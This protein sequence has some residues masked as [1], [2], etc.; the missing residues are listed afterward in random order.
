MVH[1]HYS[2][3]EFST[4]S[5]AK[6]LFVSERSLQRRFKAI[7]NKTFKEYLNEIRLEKACQY[8][9]AGGKVAQVA[10]DCGFNDPSYFSQRFKHHFGLSP[11]QFV[12]DNE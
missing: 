12:D 7:T 2:D 3:P 8:L 5:A 9:L 6:S 10:F 1:N 4:S 11:T